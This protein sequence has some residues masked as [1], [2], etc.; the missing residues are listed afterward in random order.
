MRDNAFLQSAVSRCCLLGSFEH[1]C[2]SSQ[3]LLAVFLAVLFQETLVAAR[4]PLFELLCRLL[5]NISPKELVSD[6][7]IY[8]TLVLPAEVSCTFLR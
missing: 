4:F 2:C 6:N 3:A 1:A 7:A 5:Y 8:V